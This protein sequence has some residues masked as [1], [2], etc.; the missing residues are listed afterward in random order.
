[1]N[2]ELLEIIQNFQGFNS[3]M[4]Y[5]KMIVL[6][7]ESNFNEK[8]LKKFLI[9]YCL[10]FGENDINPQQIRYYCNLAEKLELSQVKKLNNSL[11]LISKGWI[12]IMLPQNNDNKNNGDQGENIKIYLSIDNNSLH[13]F[14][15]LFLI[16]CLEYGYTDLKFKINKDESLNRRD[17]V[18]VYCNEKNFS[19]YVKLIQDIIL[20]NP[21]IKF[22]SPHLLGIPYDKYIYC[23]IDSDDGKTSYTEE[24]CNAIYNGLINRKKTEEIVRFIESFK[25]K[26]KRTLIAIANMASNKNTK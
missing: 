26:Q 21:E 8:E 22:N 7:N 19:Q 11:D 12:Q 15:N 16:L 13:C 24:I 17:N 20:N 6:K 25:E 14:A 2:E 5:N 3:N 18:V 9:T 23:G 1:M 4:L 10:I